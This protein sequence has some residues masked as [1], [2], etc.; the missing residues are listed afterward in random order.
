MT[1]EERFNKWLGESHP[2][3]DEGEEIDI[4]DGDGLANNLIKDGFGNDFPDWI[5]ELGNHFGQQCTIRDEEYT[6]LGISYTYFD[7]YY[8]VSGGKRISCIATF[9][10]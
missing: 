1:Y 5:Q 10:L 6:L 4:Y 3:S 2:L 7:Y 9:S 8:I